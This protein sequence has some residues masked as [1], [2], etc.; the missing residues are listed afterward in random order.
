MR[1]PRNAPPPRAKPPRQTNSLPKRKRPAKRTTPTPRR[2][3]IRDARWALPALPKD[4]PDGVRV[5]GYNRLRHGVRVNAIRYNRDG[6]LFLT[7]AN[8]RTVHI[9]DTANGREV[10]IYRGHADANSADNGKSGIS[11]PLNVADA[12][13]LPDGERVASAGENQIHIWDLKTGK[14]LKVLTPK[15]PDTV[16][17]ETKQAPKTAPKTVAKAETKK[18]ALVSMKSI[19]A[20]DDG[21]RLVSG[22]DDKL[23]AHLGFGEGR[24]N[25]R[26]H[27]AYESHRSRG[28]AAERKIRRG[29]GYGRFPGRL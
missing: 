9:W 4:L 29:C 25:L 15:P 22:S 3:L 5:F 7:C 26:Q 18:P 20:S 10:M 27:A 21:K 28:L 6:S 16:K 24:G 1:S 17:T 8:D 2:G 14:T 23:S 12:V 11:S 13:F 19:A